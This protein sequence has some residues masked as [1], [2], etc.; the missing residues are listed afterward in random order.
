MKDCLF[1]KIVKGEIPSFKVWEDKEFMAILDIHPNTEGMTVLLTKK[2]YPSYLPEMPVAAYQRFWLAAK[3]VAQL[4]DK[5]LGIRRTAMVME[6]MGINHAHIKLYPL[7]GLEKGLQETEERVYYKKYPGF[8][9]SRS[10]PAV[11]LDELK[12]LA[13]KISQ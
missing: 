12:K 13:K 11:P 7:H 1:C 9:D 4:L 3:K 10:G 6:G 5:K 8:V 2:H